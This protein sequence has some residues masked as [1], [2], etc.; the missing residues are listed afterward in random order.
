[1][2]ESGTAVRNTRQRSAVSALLA[3][4]EGFH[5]AQDLHAMLRDRGERVGLTTVYR[6]LQGLADAGEIDVMRPPGGEHLYRRCSEGHHHH[7][8]C[9]ACGRT[10]EVAGPTVESWADRV[11]A[12]HGYTDVSHTLEIFGTCPTC[13]R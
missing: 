5:S 3:E 13:A 12:Q 2:T 10:V 11:A 1:M 6:T 9:R 4:V 8:V 7:L